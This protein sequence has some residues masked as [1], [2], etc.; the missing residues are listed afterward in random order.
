M[1]KII[2]ASILALALACLTTGVFAAHNPINLN[3]G[4]E[5]FSDAHG[6]DIPP[7]TLVTVTALTTD[8]DV[9]QVTFLWKSPIGG[10]VFSETVAVVDMDSY[11]TLEWPLVKG[12]ESDY[13]PTVP[14]DMLGDWGVQ[15]LFQGSEGKTIQG[16]EDVVRIRATSF[17]VIPEIPIIGTA[18]A[19][20]AMLSGF[21]YKL[22]KRNPK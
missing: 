9:T 8:P 15:A 7:G 11:E 14:P 22:K 2:A 5:V 21:A 10:L 17:N 20:I 6:I 12:A 18:G 3:D 1:R 4:Y 13:T 16:Y 19:S